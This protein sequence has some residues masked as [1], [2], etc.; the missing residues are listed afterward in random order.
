[1]RAPA[2]LAGLLTGVGLLLVAQR[3]GGLWAGIIAFSLWCFLPRPEIIGDYD[4][5]RIQIERYFRLEVFMGLFA[6]L[7]LYAA[8]RWCERGRWRWA[9]AAGVLVGLAASSKAPG[10]LALPAVLLAGLI[11]QPLGRRSLT[12]GRGRGGAR[13]RHGARSPTRRSASTPSTRS[14]TCS[15]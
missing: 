5:G 3:M 2:A 4:V 10:I 8:W 7:A 1:M 12:S 13:L 14:T 6:V 15:T 9:V 11:G